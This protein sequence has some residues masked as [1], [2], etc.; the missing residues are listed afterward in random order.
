MSAFSYSQHSG[1][2]FSVD[3]GT[4]SLRVRLIQLPSGKV[5]SVYESDEGCKK[6]A[7]L[8]AQTPRR[9][10][11]L[12]TDTL[13]RVLARPEFRTANSPVVVISGMA[14]SSLG[15]RELPY[16]QAPCRLE[17][18]SLIVATDIALPAPFADARV[19][20]VSG[21]A[22]PDN[23]MRGEECELLGLIQ[24]LKIPDDRK[25]RFVILPG[26]HSK[27]I[28]LSGHEIRTFRTYLTG[29]LY[30][31]LQQNSILS[32]T[33]KGEGKEISKKEASAITKRICEVV[34]AGRGMASLF[35]LRARHL[36]QGESGPASRHALSVLLVAM[37]ANELARQAG[38]G[39][40]VIIAGSAKFAALYKT[41][42]TNFCPVQVTTIRPQVVNHALVRAHMQILQ[43]GV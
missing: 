40:V 36:L 19:C 27:H 17:A 39:S 16:A 38:K 25:K 20:L 2:F 12:F 33:L 6:I 10:E 41:V 29:E 31:L 35:E 4:S 23:V 15:L 8:K 34:K 13:A 37:E 22:T 26:T 14:S 28:E 1:C 30:A 11:K 43:R 3:W 32:A 7:G 24:S 9:R 21:L 5:Q 42:I 18:S